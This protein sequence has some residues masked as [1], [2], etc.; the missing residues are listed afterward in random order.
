VLASVPG[1]PDV[2]SSPAYDAVRNR[3][4]AR[5]WSTTPPVPDAVSV[6]NRADGSLISTVSIDTT[7]PGIGYPSFFLSHFAVAYDPT[8]DVW[9]ML[10]R[11]HDRVVVYDLAGAY[12]GASALPVGFDTP[13]NYGMSVA[14]GQLFLY[15]YNNS[16]WYG[17]TVLAAQDVPEPAT[18]ALLG[19]GAGLALIIRRKRSS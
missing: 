9:L 14:N 11:G 17:F 18:I 3:L 12:I 1:M 8:Y 15:S 16:A 10:D 5:T 6:I 19:A 4:Y 2:Q 13:S 7:T